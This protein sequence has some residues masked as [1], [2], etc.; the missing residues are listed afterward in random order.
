M[1]AKGA[2]RVTNEIGRATPSSTYCLESAMCF[3]SY[4]RANNR[5]LLTG[6]HEVLAILIQ[7]QTMYTFTLIVY[8]TSIFIIYNNIIINE[9]PT[10]E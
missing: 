7:G 10:L 3:M 2:I 9:G 4:G 8:Y 5:D 6:P 1:L